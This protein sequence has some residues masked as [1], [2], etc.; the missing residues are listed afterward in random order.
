MNNVLDI[1]LWTAD[2]LYLQ[3][4]QFK[5]LEGHSDIARLKIRV[6]NTLI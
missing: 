3:V 2:T 4:C 5:N 6:V 1:F